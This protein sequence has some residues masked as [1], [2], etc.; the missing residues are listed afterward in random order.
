[1]DKC[2]RLAWHKYKATRFREYL[3]FEEARDFVR[4][5]DLKGKDAW[6]SYCKGQLKSVPPLPDTIPKAPWIVYK[7]HGW[8]GMTDWLNKWQNEVSL[9]KYER[10]FFN[11]P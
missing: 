6:R 3:S 5:L 8:V 10:Y 4:K 11:F 1:M 9:I 2:R 7:D